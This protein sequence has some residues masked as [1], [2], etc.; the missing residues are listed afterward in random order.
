[1]QRWVGRLYS[2]KCAGKKGA[3]SCTGE[4]TGE[5]ALTYTFLH[6]LVLLL[7]LTLVTGAGQG[8]DAAILSVPPSFTVHTVSA[9]E[10]LAALARAHGLPVSLLRAANP[11]IGM[12]DVELLSEGTELFMPPAAGEI[13]TLRPGQDVLS[14]ALEHGLSPGE[15]VRANGLTGLSQLAPGSLLFIPGP[16]ADPAAE[17]LPDAFSEGAATGYLWP[18]EHAGVVT[19]RFGPRYLSV[20]GNTFHRGLDIAAPEGA[21]VRAARAGM[22]SFSGWGGAYGYVVYLEHGDGSQTR[23][24]HLQAP[25]EAVGRTLAAGEGLGAVGS[26]GASTGPHLH[27]E[28]RFQGEA[29]DPQPYLDTYAAK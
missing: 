6:C 15:V 22:V 27:F 29:V 18:L 7:L 21:V 28:L 10:T 17:I 19:S 1:M 4:P 23:Y 13:V 9:G 3:G 14:T 8:A 2:Q 5:R 12:G 16:I 11:S 20:A 25:G 26:S 24:A